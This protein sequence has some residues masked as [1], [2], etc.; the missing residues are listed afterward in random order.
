V[1]VLLLAVLLG[2]ALLTAGGCGPSVRTAGLADLGGPGA[3]AAAPPPTEAFLVQVM[4]HP[5]TRPAR[6]VSVSV[7][8]LSRAVPAPPAPDAATREAMRAQ[9]GARGAQVLVLSRLD[10]PWRKAFYGVGYRYLPV[11]AGPGDESAPPPPCDGPAAV[12]AVN[13]AR[14]EALACMREAQ[15]ARPALAGRVEIVFDVDPFGDVM[16]GAATPASSRDGVLQRCALRAVFQQD[17]G[18]PRAPVCRGALRVELGPG[19]QP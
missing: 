6:R 5:P 12:V 11:G 18:R 8:T 13:E 16:R 7:A 2:A 14:A 9:A 3:R 15:R 1:V 19:G 10:T 17:Y 4:E